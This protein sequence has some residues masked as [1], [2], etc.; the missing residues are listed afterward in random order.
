MQKKLVRDN[1]EIME[2]FK[3]R[4][5]SQRGI[6]LEFQDGPLEDSL[7]ISLTYRSIPS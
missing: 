6:G 2:F 4:L 1:Y 7:P 3:K 5:Q